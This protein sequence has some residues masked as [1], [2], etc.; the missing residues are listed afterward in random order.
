MSPKR[1]PRGCGCQ[2][3]RNRLVTAAERKADDSDNPHA[4]AYRL[5]MPLAVDR[6]LLLGSDARALAEWQIPEFPLKGGAIVARGITAGPAVARILQMVE[7]SWVAEGFPGP[8][9]IEQLLTEALD[10]YSPAG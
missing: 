6:L 4:L 8:A 5:T 3:Q 1:W 2:A 10:G 7:Q 9:R